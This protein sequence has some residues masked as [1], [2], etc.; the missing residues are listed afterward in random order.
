MDIGYR[1]SNCIG[2][3][4]RAKHTAELLGKA[5]SDWDYRAST[6]FSANTCG[7]YLAMR[8]IV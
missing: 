5:F 3:G 4:A 8:K 6:P 2:I 1:Y 7:L